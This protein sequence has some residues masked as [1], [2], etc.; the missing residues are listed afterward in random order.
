MV[1]ELKLVWQRLTT[2]PQLA[3]W[4]KHAGLAA[5]E[6]L[7]YLVL[8]EEAAT[9]GE[10]DTGG[11]EIGPLEVRIRSFSTSRAVAVAMRDAV[12][13]AFK[14]FQASAAG[15]R[16][17]D[18]AISSSS[19]MLDPERNDEGEEVWTGV[20]GLSLTVQRAP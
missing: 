8:D 15:V 1:D 5:D 7:P 20:L 6:R 12:A 16:V 14:D 11:T 4:P 19:V 17:I 13:D 18:T 2:A 9:D 3:A 10:H